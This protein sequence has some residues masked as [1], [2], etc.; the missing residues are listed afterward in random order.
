[1]ITLPSSPSHLWLLSFWSVLIL[2]VG[3]PVGVVLWIFV[4]P[5]WFGLDVMILVVVALAGLLRPRSL[6]R[7]YRFWN[8]I[9]KSFACYA[10][11]WLTGICFYG[12]FF[13]VGWAGSSLRLK[14]PDSSAESLWEPRGRLPLRA[15]CS[16]Y[17]STTT[18]SNQHGWIS[19]NLLERTVG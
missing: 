17:Y 19:T 1:M 9:A 11:Q 13:P 6:L 10:R 2:F 14:R 12:I 8:K 16:Q 4:S 15:Y 5:L 7:P 3:L 18:E